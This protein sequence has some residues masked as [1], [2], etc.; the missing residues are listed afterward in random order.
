[1]KS[2]CF[3]TTVAQAFGIEA[4]EESLHSVCIVT[5][6]EGMF[7]DTSTFDMAQWDAK[8]YF[9]HLWCKRHV[10]NARHWWI[11]FIYHILQRNYCFMCDAII[12]QSCLSFGITDDGCIAR[13]RVIALALVKKRWSPYAINFCDPPKWEMEVR[14]GHYSEYHHPSDCLTKRTPSE[15][16]IRYFYY[17]YNLWYRH[18]PSFFNYLDF[19]NNDSHVD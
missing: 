11:C 14:F 17:K 2:P 5:V 12:G 19:R 6:L 10:S 8:G 3:W 7:L 4:L 16:H 9:H 1:M 13:K 15:V 18:V